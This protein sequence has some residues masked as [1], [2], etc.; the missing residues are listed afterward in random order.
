MTRTSDRREGG[1]TLIEILVVVTILAT[2]MGMVALL[3]PM[4]FEQGDETKSQTWVRQVSAAI[5]QLQSR[6]SLGWFPPTSVTRLR[7]TTGT[8]IGK[9]LGEGNDFNRG[10]ECVFVAL[11]LRGVTIRVDLPDDA[12]K[13]TDGDSFPNNVTQQDSLER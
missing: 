2:L 5:T 3:A 6:E 10:I 9:D 4:V 8:K 11:H 1:F 13:N 12:L 7:D